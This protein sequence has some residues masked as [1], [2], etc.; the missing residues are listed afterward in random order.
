VIA[1][2]NDTSFPSGFQIGDARVA[3]YDELRVARDDGISDGKGFIGLMV[4]E[5][6]A[7]TKKI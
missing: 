5:I 3:L 1:E 6:S 4:M 7:S 2:P